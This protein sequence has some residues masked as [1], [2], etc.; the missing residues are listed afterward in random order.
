MTSGEAPV[1]QSRWKVVWVAILAAAVAAASI[2][3]VPP[4]LPDL[5]V[6]LVLT[7]VAAGWV[8]SIFNVLGLAIGP[9]V[10]VMGDAVGHR[11]FMLFGLLALMLGGLLGWTAT[12]AT[13]LL[14][15]RV[16]E[17]VGFIS[18]I[19]AAP[20][21]I[22]KAVQPADRRLALGAFSV[23]MSLGIAPILLL[24]PAFM[25]WAGWRGLWIALA[26]VTLASFLLLI[27]VTRER[28]PMALAPKTRPPAELL[29]DLRAT[30]SRWGLWWMALAFAAYTF[31]WTAILVWLP[32]FLVESRGYDIGWAAWLTVPF[33][34]VN[35]V[36]ALFG[37]WLLQRGVA[38]A[39]L[40]IGGNVVL[41]VGDLG[42][43]AAALPD[44]ARYG[45]CVL[46]SA[47]AG[48]LPASVIAG[49]AIYAPEPGRIATANGIV[50]QGSNLGQ[51]LGPTLVA[52]AIT[53]FG[54]WESASTLLVAV[55]LI[56]I[57]AG[58]AAIRCERRL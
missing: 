37:G 15:S 44:L 50:V 46:A 24:A 23:Y 54:N 36:G 21:L 11:R 13:L 55:A 18:V 12:G 5:R 29:H 56:G 33:V 53:T 6:E 1:E 51:M 57:A 32:S 8:A 26:A 28:A 39:W 25:A 10:G 31:Q 47:L 22:L 40:L 48:I 14:A 20:G 19:V 4:A 35:G 16:L 45:L 52:A 42:L 7:M 3:K 9:F 58:W 17:G 30:L 38:R 2:G 34:I 49:T 43:F 27:G 41:G